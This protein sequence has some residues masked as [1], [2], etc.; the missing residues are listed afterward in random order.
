MHQNKDVFNHNGGGTHFTGNQCFWL[1]AAFFKLKY[2]CIYWQVAA[3]GESASWSLVI[4]HI[5]TYVR[6]QHRSAVYIYWWCL[7]ARLL[8]SV[9]Y[10]F[11]S[12]KK[13]EIQ[14]LCEFL[15]STCD[16]F[17]PGRRPCQTATE[18]FTWRCSTVWIFSTQGHARLYLFIYW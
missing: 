15:L 18:S 4:H 2:K 5:R 1:M 6:A 7:R 10:A 8:L 13:K 3:A 16:W 17:V 11:N 14:S 12:I 9:Y